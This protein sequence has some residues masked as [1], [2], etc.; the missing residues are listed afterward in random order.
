[1]INSS[2]ILPSSTAVRVGQLVRLL[3][4]DRPG[5]VVAAVDTLKRTLANVGA[6]LH[7]LAHLIERG[8]RQRASAPL[9]TMH[10][11]ITLAR[12]CLRHE[13]TAR[14]REFIASMT[15]WRGAPTDK[16]GAWLIA[17]ASRL[18]VGR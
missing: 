1:M 14:E 8:D 13:L 15:R 5:E 7:A 6:D 17:I 9:P 16:Q 11:T 3:G 2:I 4:S 18:G 12:A 10:D